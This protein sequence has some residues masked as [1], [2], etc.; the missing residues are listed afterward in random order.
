MAAAV[1]A[2]LT[3][4]ETHFQTFGRVE[5]RSG[6]PLFDVEYYLANNPDVA[7]AVR[8]GTLTP[9]DH[10]LMFGIAEG[11]LL[12][13]LFDEDFYV[14]HNP[15]VAQAIASGQMA[16]AVQHFVLFGHREGRPIS[17]YLDLGKYLNA[18]AD[19][20]GPF[21]SEGLSPFVH[22]MEY[23]IAEGRDLGNGVKLSNFGNDPAFAQALANGDFAQAWARVAVV[24]PFMPGFERPAGWVPS[25]NAPIPVDFRAP[26]GSGLKLIVPPEVIVPDGVILSD[27]VFLLDNKPTPG[28]GGSTGPTFT[29]VPDQD[30]VLIVSSGNGNVTIT[31]SNGNYVFTPANGNPVAIP[32]GDT[33]GIIVNGV[34]VVAESAILNGIIANADAAIPPIDPAIT[35]PVTIS[36]MISATEA[37]TIAGKINGVVTA[38]LEPGSLASFNGIEAGNNFTITLNDP[39]GTN[40]PA[41]DLSALGGKTTGPVTITNAVVIGGTAAEIAAALVTPDTRVSA[42]NSVVN[43]STAANTVVDAATLRAIGGATSGTVTVADSQNMTV[44]GSVADVKAALLEADTKVEAPSAHVTLTDAVVSVADAND[45]A[46]ATGGIVTATLQSGP[47]TSFESLAET[48]NAYTITVNDD[49]GTQMSATALSALGGKTTGDV[50]VSNAVAISGTT[51]EVT[52]AL[53]TPATCVSAPTAVVTI[54]DTEAGTATT[55]LLAS[56]L[57][58][59]GGKTTGTVTVLEA[60]TITGTAADVKAALIADDTKVIAGTAKVQIS[61][62]IPVT[63]ADD[64]NGIAAATSGVV[65]A[66]LA[67]ELAI[68]SELAETNNAYTITVTDNAATNLAATALSAL[69]GKTTAPVTVA[70]AVTITGNAAEVKAALVTND[71]KVTAGTANVQISGMIPVTSAD[72]IND[73]NGIAAATNGVVTAALEGALASFA[74]LAETNNAYTITVTDASTATLTAAALSALGGK[75]TAPVTVTN[76]VTITGTAAEVTAALVTE[77]TKVIAT[78]ASV[79]LSGTTTAAQA[80]LI[81]A[82]TDGIVTATLVGALSDFSGLTE[83]NNAYTITVNDSAGTGLNATALST[84]RGTTTGTVTVT[85]AVTISGTAAELTAALITE[86]TRVIASTA[87]VIVNGAVDAGELTAIHNATNGTVTVQGTPGP[88]TYNLA[89]FAA[90]HLTINGLAGNDVINS[91]NG[92]DVI[93]GGDGDDDINGGAGNDTIQGGAGNDIIT[94]GGGND[95]LTGGSGNDT[96]RVDAGADTITD[97]AT[98]DILVVSN[99]AAATANNVSHFIATN[100]TTQG[101]SAV[102]NAAAAGATIDVSLSTGGGYALN[103]GA[104]A[105]T[106]VGSSSDDQITGGGGD[107]TLTGGLGNDTLTG[108]LG[109]DTLTGGSGNDT[110]KV[111]AGSDTITDLA[112]GDILEVSAGATATANNVTAFVATNATVQGGT[113]VL[114]AAA[115]GATINVSASTGTA[116]YT[117][118]G[119]AEADTLVGSAGNDWITGGMGA[120]RI[121][122]GTGTDTVVLRGG[123]SG[124]NNATGSS[125]NT[126]GFDIYTGLGVGDKLEIY[127]E[128]TYNRFYSVET[129]STNVSGV[130]EGLKFTRGTYDSSSNQFT[131][132]GSGTDTLLTYDWSTK[133]APEY[134]DPAPEYEAIVLVGFVGKSDWGVT[135]SGRG[136]TIT[137]EGL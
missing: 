39:A 55:P 121:N 30:G 16:S 135:E 80:N 28:G 119:G 82:A 11:R 115:G 32:K 129:S 88:D 41:T 102:L 8:A 107:D 19:L 29:V 73:I 23:G 13:P 74:G 130:L 95:T 75:T 50:T 6:S 90:G 105:D 84:L 5:G 1:R 4:A 69:K 128:T 48:N 21:A 51:A 137:L 111:D 79:T 114:N 44:N 53:V 66:S 108:G 17:P 26:A 36:D 63:S 54:T 35:G 113:A 37:N 27:Q 34:S 94:G 85:N 10:A 76:A 99:W 93:D 101:W 91:G 49:A 103:G 58:A 118:N 116:G 120:D 72:D 18:N 123:H 97:L 59:I 109:N 33:K 71:T 22:L 112:T 117:L 61:D 57:S 20:Q 132:G 96:F 52:A 110:F 2:G 87:N 38:T 64:I 47:L 98:G 92:N 43:I 70:N 86:A 67:G 3:D 131:A 133:R 134:S 89:S 65:T 104:A 100:A 45:I 7:A 126:S 122:V 46:A 68:F 127:R 81:A 78:A 14:R 40:M 77:A 56:D 31:E 62:M 106:L 136:A 25:A 124:A 24:S 12:S 9:W 125:V 60:V 15:D 83:T 42:P